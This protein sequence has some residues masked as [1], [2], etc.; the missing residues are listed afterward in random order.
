MYRK[1]EPNYL[2]IAIAAIIWGSS[3]AFV[4]YLGL[5]PQV[6]SFFRLGIPTVLLGLYFLF[7]RDPLF[8]NNIRLLLIASVLNAVRL[9]FYF[10]GFLNAPIGNAIMILYT[11]PVFAVIFSRIFLKEPLPFWNRLLLVGAMAGIILIYSDKPF[12][13]NDE[14]FWGMSAMLISAVLYAVTVIIFKKESLKYNHLQIVFFQNLVGAVLFLPFFVMDFNLL[15]LH[16]AS[17]AS[18]YAFAV[19]VVGFGLFFFSL[20]RIK[21]SNASFLAYIEVPSAVLF[22]VFLFHEVLSWNEILGGAM[23]IGASLMLKR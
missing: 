13:L 1:L 12:S 22:G 14:V 2:K 23:I 6:I 7:R 5:P 9:F 15:T 11:W 10:I 3:G 18:L 19:G 21:A 8:R 4:K 16:N 17:V 20:K